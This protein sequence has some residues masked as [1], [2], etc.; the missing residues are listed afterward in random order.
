VVDESCHGSLLAS[1]AD[2]YVAQEAGV[3]ALPER[4]H[5]DIREE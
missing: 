3:D 1:E 5:A 4:V 2:I